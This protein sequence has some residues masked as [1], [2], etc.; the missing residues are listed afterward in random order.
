MTPRGAYVRLTNEQKGR[1]RQYQDDNPNSTLRDLGA[2]ATTAFWFDSST[3]Q[4]TATR[5][6]LRPLKALLRVSR[7][8]DRSRLQSWINSCWRGPEVRGAHDWV[9]HRLNHSRESVA[10]VRQ[11]GC[12][13]QSKQR[14]SSVLS[15]SQTTGCRSSSSGTLS[16][17]RVSTAKSHLERPGY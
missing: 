17:P 8:I 9:G 13:A 1:A 2:W 12:R 3:L 16:P 5:S 6:L 10:L 15:R 11:D 7:Q 14:P 4:M